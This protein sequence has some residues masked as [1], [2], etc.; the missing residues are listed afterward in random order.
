LGGE[1]NERLAHDLRT[2]FPN[3][4]GFSPRNLK[5]M[6]A[7]AGA[8]SD[9]EFVQQT[10]AQLLWFHLC[11]LLDKLKNREERDWYMA[12]FCRMDKRQRIHQY[13]Q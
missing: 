1:G 13:I 5:Y 7:F 4:K 3:I 11:T 8:W 9:A 6:R 10:A 2:A 12:K